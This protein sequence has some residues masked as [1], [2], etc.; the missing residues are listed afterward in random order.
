MVFG[1]NLG[2]R[3][4]IICN[5]IFNIDNKRYALAR[6]YLIDVDLF[7]ENSQFGEFWCRDWSLTQCMEAPESRWEPNFDFL[8][9]IGARRDCIFY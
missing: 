7:Q 6:I 1:T 4:N 9:L 5:S 2:H 8:S 3:Q